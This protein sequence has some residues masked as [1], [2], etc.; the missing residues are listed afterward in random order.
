LEIPKSL[1]GLAEME[2]A[3][4]TMDGLFRELYTEL[5]RTAHAH[6]RRHGMHET[7][8]TTALVNEAYLRLRQAGRVASQDRL[9]FLA[10]S[11]RAMRFALIDYAR[12]SH[13]E[14]RGAGAVRR[15][16]KPGDDLGADV[17]AVAEATADAESLLAVHAALERMTTLHA[18]MAQVVECRF[19]GG[20]T[21][22][23]IAELLGV[24]LR[25]VR[26]DWQRAKIWLARDLGAGPAS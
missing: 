2:G 4:V 16:D 3:A 11:A 1:P 8:S 22:E 17:A 15:A 24:S 7:M 6:R 18:R 9:H 26:G 25:T 13:A 20:M 10:L 12:R 19:F 23:E 5:R 14:K 21:E